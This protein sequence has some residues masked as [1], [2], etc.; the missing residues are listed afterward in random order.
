MQ[1]NT[2]TGCHRDDEMVVRGLG[3]LRPAPG[4]ALLIENVGNLVCPAPFDLGEHAKI[5]VFSV[6]EGEDKPVKY[7]HMF[8]AASLV[9]PNKI[10]LLPHLDF[11][12]DRA[13]ANI[14]AVNSS[15]AVSPVSARAGEGTA[16]W[17]EWLWRQMVEARETAFG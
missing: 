8:G 17:Y 12:V 11:D 15:A 3:Q 13:L 1:V 6:A 10:D 4:A 16:G 7:P 2:G 5:A 14:R 9:I